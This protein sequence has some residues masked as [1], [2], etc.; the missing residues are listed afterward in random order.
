M[1]LAANKALV[2]R[3]YT[4]VLS[5]SRLEALDELLAEDFTSWMA[6]GTAVGPDAYR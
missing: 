6:D 3:Y 4:D 1:G 5:G 2:T